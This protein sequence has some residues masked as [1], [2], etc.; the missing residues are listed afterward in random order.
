[1][2]RAPLTF[3][4]GGAEGYPE[5]A[6]ADPATMG[7]VQPRSFIWGW[8]EVEEAGE[9][10]L[11]AEGRDRAKEVGTVAEKAR[12]R[13]RKEE[14]GQREEGTK[15]R[16]G[17][18]ERDQGRTRNHSWRDVGNHT[19]LTRRSGL[20]ER[21]RDA[22]GLLMRGSQKRM[23]DALRGIVQRKQRRRRSSSL[24]SLRSAWKGHPSSL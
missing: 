17:E 8:Y 6:A 20:E 3:A 7:G 15:V 4:G 24:R 2:E 21:K 9:V 11:V 12:V 1:V 10:R 22:L 23:R 18:T 5:E 16:E 13:E 19:S 14:E